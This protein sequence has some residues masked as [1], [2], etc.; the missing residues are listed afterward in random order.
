MTGQLQLDMDRSAEF[1]PCR[2]WRYV[3]RRIWDDRP[4]AMFIGLNPSTADETQDDPTIRRCIRF[5]R[6]WGCGGLLMTNLYAFRSTDPKGLLTAADPIGPAN[7]DWLLRCSSDAVIIIAAW[8]SW[9]T[10]VKPYE[11]RPSIIA[12]VV[13]PQ[14]LYCLG[15]TKDGAPRHPLYIPADTQPQLWPS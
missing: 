8:G 2:T 14:T 7:N 11:L 5:A 15:E 6:D 10:K 3:L 1:S 13:H 12:G 9:G 4:P